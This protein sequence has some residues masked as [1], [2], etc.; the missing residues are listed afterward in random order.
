MITRRL[1]YESRRIWSRLSGIVSFAFFAGAGHTVVGVVPNGGR[2]RWLIRDGVSYLNLVSTILRQD[3]QSNAFR[4]LV[5]RT[6]AN[7][8]FL[9][10][11]LFD[12]RSVTS[13]VR[14]ILQRRFLEN[15]QFAISG[16]RQR[17]DAYAFPI[18]LKRSERNRIKHEFFTNLNH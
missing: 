12:I 2:S 17:L 16:N 11:D 15:R 14:R 4:T 5:Q 13:P 7:L 1:E 6:Y 18:R 8:S 9:F 3:E 10:P